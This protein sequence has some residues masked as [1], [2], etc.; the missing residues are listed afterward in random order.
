MRK[1]STLEQ[2]LE[3]VAKQ[4][5]TNLEIINKK[6][7]T[8]LEVLPEIFDLPYQ[9][10]TQRFEY[11]SQLQP[12][13]ENIRQILNWLYINQPRGLLHLTYHYLKLAS[14]ELLP[15][16]TILSIPDT[17][18]REKL[19]FPHEKSLYL[20]NALNEYVD[21][22]KSL[23]NDYISIRIGYRNYSASLPTLFRMLNSEDDA[24]EHYRN[25]RCYGNWSAQQIKIARRTYLGTLSATAFIAI[26]TLVI[27][28]IMNAPNRGMGLLLV[29][30]GFIYIFLVLVGCIGACFIG[31]KIATEYF[32][33][34]IH[35][36]NPHHN[37]AEIPMADLEGL[38][39]NDSWKLIEFMIHA[40]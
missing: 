12:D 1:K 16:E 30:A 29:T 35:P 21:K 39:H 5:K 4:I 8:L 22:L 10:L 19:L 25:Q 20:Y 3:E 18:T 38:R 27:M 6:L 32:A 13:A 2:E 33:F 15:P 34:N 40:K 17:V 7:S 26:T 31:G 28:M 24:L 23:D 36:I 11:L 37:A 14:P 9:L